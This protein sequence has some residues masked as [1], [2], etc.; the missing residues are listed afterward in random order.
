[1]SSG[2]SGRLC[3]AGTLA[4]A[5]AQ[6]AR[7]DARDVKLWP[8]FRYAS[9]E[10]HQELRWSA[11][12]PFIEYTQTAD[13]RDFRIRPFLWLRQRRGPGRDDRAE[14]LYPLAATRWQDDYQS[15]RFLLFT[16]RLGPERSEEVAPPPATDAAAAEPE[17]R[18]TLFP[19]VFYRW[20]PAEGTQF[21]VLPFYLDFDDFMGWDHVRAIMA[22]AYLRLTTARLDRRYYAFPFFSTVSGADGH[23]FRAWPF[24]GDTETID[25]GETRF[26]L[27]PFHIR[28]RRFVPGYGEERR[29]INFPAFA[30]IDGAGRE[31]RAYGLFAYTHSV[32]TRR[33]TESVGA[34]WPLVVRERRLGEDEYYLWRLAPF[35]GRSE[36]DG[37]SSRFY[38]W[39]AYRVR[40]QDVEDFHYTRR[41]VGWILWR[42]Q[43]LHNTASGR[44]EDL[45]TLFPALRAEE[46]NGR[47]FG[48]VPA[49]ADSLMPKNRGVLAMWAPLYGWLRWDTRPT[50]ARDW[51]LLWGLAARENTRLVGPW[52]LELD[53]AADGG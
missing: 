45:L 38:A 39:P 7:V 28:T 29:R 10:A 51:N 6:P 41:D 8:L 4:L 33:G 11:L 42:R 36:V 22:P 26:V 47:R 1:L 53:E 13:F 32:D 48:Q 18:I 14:I 52:H 21:G 40:S 50:G 17:E 35:Y 15:F 3:L 9:D 25:E 30:A 19:F 31:S 24:Y 46:E 12:G 2:R 34:P 23:G 27:W 43:T 20:T 5:L 44:Q 49:L 37:I 16:Y